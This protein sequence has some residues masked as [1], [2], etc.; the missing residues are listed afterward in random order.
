MQGA[1]D[2]K[3]YLRG[4]PVLGRLSVALSRKVIAIIDDD[5]AVL[6]GMSSL[7]ETLGYRT[8]VYSSGEEFINAA[9]KSD[10]ACLLID[11]HLGDITGFELIRHVA[12]MGPLLPVIFMTGAKDAALRKEAIYFGAVA[13]LLKPFPARQLA[14]AITDA[15]G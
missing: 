5:T 7:I 6:D 10:A 14:Q 3:P 2:E 13:C 12:T 1:L 9:P 4:R 15:I 11:I 8:E